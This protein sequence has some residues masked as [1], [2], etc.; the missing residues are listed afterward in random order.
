MN[1]TFCG[2][3]AIRES[4]IRKNQPGIGS[5]HHDMPIMALFAFFQRADSVLPKLDGSV[6]TAVPLSTITTVKEVKQVL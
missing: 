4:F 2:D 6:S 3:S 1:F 5:G